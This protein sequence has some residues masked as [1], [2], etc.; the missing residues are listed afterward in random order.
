ME[1]ALDRTITWTEH[2]IGQSSYLERVVT[3]RGCLFRGCLFGEV[4][5]GV[6]MLLLKTVV[7]LMEE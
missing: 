3:W 4:L 1:N 2:L 6:D 7:S 5:F